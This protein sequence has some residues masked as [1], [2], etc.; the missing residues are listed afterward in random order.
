MTTVDL[1]VEMYRTYQRDLS[2][3]LLTA[4]VVLGM[5]ILIG[6]GELLP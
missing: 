5:A 6:L 1:L 2:L 3:V 4:A